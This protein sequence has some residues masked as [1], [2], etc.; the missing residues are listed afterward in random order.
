MN[1]IEFGLLL[2]KAR[3]SRNLTQKDIADLMHY[4]AQTVSLWEKGKVDMKLDSLCLFANHLKYSFLGF[5]EWK[6][7]EEEKP[8]S[9]DNEK[10]IHALIEYGNE[11]HFTVEDL[12]AVL[13]VSKPTLRKILK[14]EIVLSLWQY[15]HFCTNYS[16]N[17]I[18]LFE[19]KEETTQEWIQE[20]EKT[21]QKK[22]SLKIILGTA[23][24]LIIILA[25]VLP[26]TICRKA[27]PN[28]VD[29]VSSS[30]SSDVEETSSSLDS[31]LSA[32]SSLLEKTKEETP[33]ISIDAFS[34]KLTGFQKNRRYL[35]NDEEYLLQEDSL[36]IEESWHLRQISISLI[37]EDEFHLNS[38][39]QILYINSMDFENYFDE[40]N[41]DNVLTNPSM[42]DDLDNKIELVSSSYGTAGNSIHTLSKDEISL[43]KENLQTS[44]PYFHDDVF[45]SYLNGMPFSSSL[46]I[47]DYEIKN[48]DA[49]QYVLIHGVKESEKNS[50]VE[51]SIPKSIEGIEDIRIDDEAFM[52]KS[53]VQYEKLTSIIFEEKPHYIGDN[54]FCGLSLNILDFGFEDDLSYSID[55]H[56]QSRSITEDG[57][58]YTVQSSQAFKGLKHVDKLRLPLRICE[59]D[60]GKFYNVLFDTGELKLKDYAITDYWGINALV[61]PR[62]KTGSYS[63]KGNKIANMKIYSLYIPKN[64]EFY[65][66]FNRDLYLR[67]VRFEKGYSFM[68]S[69]SEFLGSKYYYFIGCF[70]L[71]YYLR[72]ISSTY[73]IP[74]KFLRG[75]LS[76][77]GI[78]DYENIS[79][80]GSEAFRGVLLPRKIALRNVKTISEKAFYMPFHLEQV[81][82]YKSEGI[83]SS[84]PL[85]LSSN[86]FVNQEGS[87]TKIKKI[88]FHNFADD[89]ISRNAAYKSEDILEERV[90]D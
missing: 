73:E 16:L 59:E 48:E 63:Y 41:L 80:I 51:I 34:R 82:I 22:K 70:A 45:S 66:E 55:Y 35:I 64:V 46:S 19:Q 42:D 49:K 72:D 10:F 69:E 47:L 65:P 25:V 32:S 7:I 85:I 75:N 76:F 23:L 77:R 3:E 27:N 9:F 57:Y 15:H 28:I 53:T 62:P 26:L 50:V 11:N 4:S 33:K 58:T 24:S 31:S 38:D 71:Q 54:A 68:K 40:E 83:S 61:L 56:F 37:A 20:E 78:L 43:L 89:E 12:R 39:K 2:K 84:S 79:S 36:D 30:F 6:L 88:V 52:V 87:K 86:S 90:T 8:F 29:S 44:L 81:D 13:D 67:L 21:N 60:T 17:P 18:F 5:L 74:S 1:E 14:G